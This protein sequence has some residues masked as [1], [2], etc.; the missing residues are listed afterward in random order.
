MKQLSLAG[1]NLIGVA[2]LVVMALVMAACGS[3]ETATPTSGGGQTQTPTATS[4]SGGQTQTPSAT[5]PATP[6]ATA[7][8]NFFEGKTITITVG[9]TAGG[10]YD[11]YARLVSNHLSEHIPGNPT[12][13]V[14]NQP[15]AGGLLAANHIYSAAPKD[16]TEIGLTIATL[17]LSQFNEEEG[18]A[19]DV[20]EMPQ[21]G[22]PVSDNILV[23][24][25]NDYV[26]G[27][28]LQEIA[29]AIAGG[30]EPPIFGGT[31][32][33]A[34][35]QTGLL[36]EMVPGFDFDSVIGYPGNTEVRLAIRQGEVDGASGS[37][38]SFLEQLGDMLE[39]GDMVIINQTGTADLER[40]PAYPDAPTLSELAD[41]PF[42]NA[43]V[44]A[45]IAR[46]V[47]GRP[48]F[49]PP[50][51]PE[52]RVQLLK[53]ALWATFNDPDFLAEAE[54]LGRPVSAVDGDRVAE[55]YEAVFDVDPAEKARLQE[56]LSGAQE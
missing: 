17:Y 51:V 8:D 37:E 52:N 10:G 1:R 13:I 46:S 40:D 42:E 21:L 35:I 5:A 34:T 29:D 47:A 32:Q 4:G 6:T 55:L 3:D 39:S 22:S 20:R 44:N 9:F 18:V 56:L 15:G 38:S 25:H 12:V 27:R 54:Q 48:F 26:Q 7:E 11:A 14:N 28:S 30:A 31:D 50:G 33:G 2:L 19:F 43:A 16:G 24:L 23:Y 36:R 53:D 45:Y 41:S 49:L